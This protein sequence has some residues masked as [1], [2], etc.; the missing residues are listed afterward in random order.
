MDHGGLLWWFNWG[1]CLVENVVWLGMDFLLKHLGTF[2][3][4]LGFL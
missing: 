4:S 1:M 2:G 3:D